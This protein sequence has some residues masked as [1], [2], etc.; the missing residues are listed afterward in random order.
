MHWSESAFADNEWLMTAAITEDGMLSYSDCCHNRIV[1][2][3]D[4][5]VTELAADVIPTGYFEVRNGALLWTGAAEVTCRDCV[6]EL[7]AE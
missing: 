7:P 1:T 4:G 5:T 3:E 2:A 6:F